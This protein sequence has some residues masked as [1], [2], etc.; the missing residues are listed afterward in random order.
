MVA[1]IITLGEATVPTDEE[2]P[3]FNMKGGDPQPQ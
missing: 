3:C 1:R 2:I